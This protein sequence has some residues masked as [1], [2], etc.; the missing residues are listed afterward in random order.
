MA[1]MAALKE[2]FRR[3]RWIEVDMASVSYTHLDI[4]ILLD[5][6]GGV[7]V[8]QGMEISIRDT[9]SFQQMRILGDDEEKKH[10]LKNFYIALEMALKI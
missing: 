1:E 4:H 9:R 7:G 3:E 5:A 10:Q 8:P 2:N 6:A